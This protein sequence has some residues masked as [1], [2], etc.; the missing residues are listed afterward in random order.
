MTQLILN[1]RGTSLSVKGGRYCVRTPERESFIP[2]HEIKSIHLHSATKLTY[3]VVQTAIQYNTDLLFIDRYGKP[4]GR[5]WSNQ[6]GS[7]STIRKNQLAFS[8]SLQGGEWVRSVL[9]QKAENQVLVL[10]MLQLLTQKE[11]AEALQTLAFYGQKFKK[12]AIKELPEAFATFR[13]YEGSLSRAYFG[14]IRDLLPQQYCFAKRSQHPALD[15]FNALLNYAYGMLYSHCESALIRA[16]IDPA[17]GVMHRDEYNRPVL[18]YDFIESYRHYADYVVCHLC[19][20]EVIFEEFF[21]VEKGQFWLNTD[22]KRLLIQCMND[23]LN[24]VVNIQG[25]SR[26]RL[27]H[28]EL[29]AQRLATQLKKMG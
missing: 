29:D 11:C 25:L 24:E 14:A 17:V 1:K 15:M 12:Y 23:Y 6:F 13:G 27:T 10:E 22:G 4:I 18:V 9:F 28:L 8:Q 16:G 2:V 7:I 26:S 5:V 3:E 20:Q 19:V 21:E